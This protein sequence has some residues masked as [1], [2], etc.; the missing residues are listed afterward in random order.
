MTTSKFNTYGIVRLTL[1][2]VLFAA[3]IFFIYVFFSVVFLEGHI[4]PRGTLPPFGAIIF[5]CFFTF[6]LCYIVYSWTLYSF[7]IEIDETGKTI[8]FKNIITRKKKLYN[9]SDF[10]GYLD[11]FVDIN[12]YREGRRQH[13]VIYLVKD[14]RIEKIIT[15]FY[16]ENMDELLEAL[17][18]LN[19]YGFEK[20]FSKL[21]R[22]ALLKKK[23]FDNAKV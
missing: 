20:D 2:V 6:V 22:K 8:C 17:S 19:Y 14:N 5:I 7:N 12:V 23:V 1:S 4:I 21:A 13:K 15:G 16:Y 9:F 10:D 18:P 3:I 11:T